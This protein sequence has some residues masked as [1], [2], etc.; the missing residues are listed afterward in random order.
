MVAN[1]RRA[2]GGAAACAPA[3]HIRRGCSA[4]FGYGLRR[5]STI[6][7]E[8]ADIQLCAR[9]GADITLC[10]AEMR[11]AQSCA[12]HPPT[13]VERHASDPGIECRPNESRQLARLLDNG[14]EDCADIRRAVRT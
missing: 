7:L 5:R 3:G 2:E 14:A 8:G 11:K 4:S 13:A 1:Q 6:L 10:A 9:R 12:E